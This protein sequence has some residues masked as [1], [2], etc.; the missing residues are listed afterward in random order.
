MEKAH[1]NDAEYDVQYGEQ[2]N[3]GLSDV[4]V[5]AGAIGVAAI[6]RWF[7]QRH[8]TKRKAEFDGDAVRLERQRLE[9]DAGNARRATEQARRE[10]LEGQARRQRLDR[11]GA[12]QAGERI[13]TTTDLELGRQILNIQAKA[14]DFWLRH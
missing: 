5:V 14:Y 7:A 10:A 2:H 8:A 4:L 1:T 9:Q 3:D 13:S 12:A 11:E 6:A